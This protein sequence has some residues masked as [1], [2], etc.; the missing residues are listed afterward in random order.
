MGNAVKKALREIPKIEPA[1]RVLQYALM[2]CCFFG[3][4]LWKLLSSIGNIAMRNA[5]DYARNGFTPPVTAAS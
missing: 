1:I 4:L 3:I 5:R 2:P